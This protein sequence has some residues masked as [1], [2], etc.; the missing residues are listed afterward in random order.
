LTVAF[1]STSIMMTQ[2]INSSLT[3]RVS[4]N[5]A[6]S[7]WLDGLSYLTAIHW[8]PATPFN[9]IWIPI[10]N[11]NLVVKVDTDTGDILGTYR[12]APAGASGDPSRTT[13]DRDGSVWCVPQ[14]H[15]NTIRFDVT[16]DHRGMYF[17]ICSFH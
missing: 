16:V 13:V 17:L 12:T 3:L 5:E 6:S 9:F 11:L 8:T 1:L 2:M 10:S 4:S 15:Y 14:Y 7:T